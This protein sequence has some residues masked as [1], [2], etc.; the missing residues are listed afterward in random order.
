[1]EQQLLSGPKD[2]SMLSRGD[3]SRIYLSDNFIQR[4][5]NELGGIGIFVNNAGLYP[6]KATE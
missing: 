1:M 2:L 5:E 3:Y 4:V 6:P